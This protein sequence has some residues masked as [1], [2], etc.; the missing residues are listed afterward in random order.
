MIPS[1]LI[2]ILEEFGTNQLSHS[3]RK[4]LEHLG[5]T[6]QLLKK[7]GNPEDIALAGL[8]HS[9]YSTQSYKKQ[10]VP[11]EEREKV[12]A[13]IGEEAEKIAFLFCEC[14]R[15]SFYG[16]PEQEDLI[17]VISRRTHQVLLIDEGIQQALLEIEAANIVEQH[18]KI[19][20]RTDPNR[21]I[22][23]LTRLIEW[24]SIL[25]SKAVAALKE[26]LDDFQK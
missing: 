10:A 8:F 6:Y 18:P 4:L 22:P 11:F 20:D 25:S 14:D 26:C 15:N 23:I 19:K 13:A 16:A 3:G 9:I 2:T 17:P 1:Q 24:E 21:A 7:W 5:G 12:V